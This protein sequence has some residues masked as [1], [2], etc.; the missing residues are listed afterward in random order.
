MISSTRCLL[1]GAMLVASCLLSHAAVAADSLDAASRNIQFYNLTNE[2]GLSSEFINDVAQ[3]GL[4]YLWFATQAGLN[5]FDG[6]SVT[7]Y[8][9]DPEDASSLAHSFI[10]ALHVDDEGT[11]W[12]ATDGGV[13]AY[14]P[15]TDSFRRNVLGEAAQAMRAR[16]ITQDG[17]GRFWIGTVDDGLV[18]VDPQTGDAVQFKHDAA[19]DGSL[20]DDHIF[21]L[22]TDGSGNLW[23]GT[24]DGLARYDESAKAFVRF[25][26][27]EGSD[28]SL[29]HNAIRSIF[30]DS[31]GTLWVGTAEGGLNVFDAEAGSFSHYQHDP[32][33]PNSLGSGQ[34]GAIFEDKD[35]TLWVG[36]ESALSE[37]RPTIDGF[38][39]Y[40]NS[41]TDRKSLVSNRVR[42]MTQDASGVLWLGTQS[43][44][45]SWNYTSDTFQHYDK[46]QGFLQAD[47]VTSLSETSDGS[48]WVGTYGGGLARLD[49]GTGNIHHYRHSAD[50]ATSLNDDRVTSVHADANDTVWVGTRSAG[51]GRLDADGVF[52]RFASDPQNDNSLSGNAVTRILSARDGSLWIGVFGG[53]LNR[54]QW[55]D[56]SPV[57]TRYRHNP[58]DETSLSGDRVLAIFEDSSGQLWV[59]TENAGL[60]IFVSESESFKRYPVTA[61][62]AGDSAGTPWELYES[63]DGTFWIGTLG[64][65]LLRWSSRDRA[66]ERLEFKPFSASAGLAADIYGI[67]GDESGVL[68][69]SSNRG[70]YRF[71][72]RDG[73]VRRFDRTNGLRNNEFNLAASLKNRSGMLLFGGT[74]GLVSFDPLRLRRNARPPAIDLVARSRTATLRRAGFGSEEAVELAYTDPFVAFD[75]AALD[76]ISPDK[77]GYR[78]RLAGYDADWND[79]QGLRRAIYSSLPPGEYAFEVQASNSDGVWNRDGVAMPVR[80]LPPPWRTGWAYSLYGLIAVVLLALMLHLMQRRELVR[81]QQR[82]RLEELVRERTQALAERNEDLLLLNRRL[83]EASVTDQLTGLR[84]RRFVD[85]FID[86]EVSAVRRREIEVRQSNAQDAKPDSS[87]LLFFIMVD[88]DGFKLINDTHGHQAGDEALLEVKERLASGCRQSDIIVRWGGDEFLVIGRSASFEGTQVLAEKLRCLLADEPYRLSNG[89]SAVLSGSI[90]ISAIPFVPDHTDACGWEQVIAIAD[91]GAYLAKSNGRDAWVCIRGTEHISPEEIRGIKDNLPTLV[92]SGKLLVASSVADGISLDGSQPVARLTGS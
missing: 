36:T 65:G 91:Q 27:E 17:P 92:D 9:H 25:Q 42:A 32:N 30:E 90:G 11:L 70:L 8:E 59:G 87:R 48:I 83:K 31:A 20:P 6:H 57:F 73:S 61:G 46:A 39:N 14:D 66:A 29:S 33:D 38:V 78:Y 71:N 85:Q 81:A 53:G 43:G 58:D 2:D 45:S 79:S 19:S 13:I 12:V 80:V 52:T 16:V 72:P 62:A 37:W 47:F 64:D 50:N 51:L 3:D 40:A 68:W 88:L 26:H 77:N 44:V 7:V 76:F 89:H 56:G 55:N 23:V 1:F 22:L 4:G 41:A 21:D 28:G 60:N 15:A 82:Q 35:G 67:L 10:W 34:V 84:N 63:A 74:S 69:L 5:R 86:E 54:L 24:G 18:S 49:L 75:F